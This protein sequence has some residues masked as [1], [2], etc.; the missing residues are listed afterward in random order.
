MMEMERERELE[1]VASLK[2]FVQATINGSEDEGEH[3]RLI[4]EIERLRRENAKLNEV[5]I[6]VC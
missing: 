3:Q 4:K 6:K 1:D 2:A 5:V